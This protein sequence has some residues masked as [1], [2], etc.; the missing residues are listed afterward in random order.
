MP[1]DPIEDKPTLTAEC[2]KESGT[3]TPASDDGRP[4]YCDDDCLSS[5]DRPADEKKPNYGTVGP[6]KCAYDSDTKPGSRPE[7]ET[8]LTD[9]KSH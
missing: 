5:G 1:T 2:V 6:V 3:E 8:T 4:G 9:S 7:L